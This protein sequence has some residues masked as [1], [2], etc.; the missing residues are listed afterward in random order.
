MPITIGAVEMVP[1]D[2]LLGDRDGVVRMPGALADDVTEKAEAAMA[3]ESAV[4]RA[5]LDG[6]DPQEASPLRQVL[7]RP[8]QSTP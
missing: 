2:L 5:I 3:T 4:R 6:I 1:G 7:R 8:T